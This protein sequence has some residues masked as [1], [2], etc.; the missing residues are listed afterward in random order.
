MAGLVGFAMRAVFPVFVLA[1]DSG[2]VLRFVSVDDMQRGL[3]RIDIENSEYDAWDR[4]GRPLNLAVQE[5]VWLNITIEGSSKGRMTLREALLL[6]ASRVGVSVDASIP[7]D[8]DLF[9]K[10]AAS[11]SERRRRRP[12]LQRLLFR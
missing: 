5:P 9:E 3:E 8:H 7:D 2:E 6:Y 4:D 1:K 10:I 12:L 11:A